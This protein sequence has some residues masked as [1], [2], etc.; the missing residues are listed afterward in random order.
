MLR[1]SRYRIIDRPDIGPNYK[2]SNCGSAKEGD[3]KYVDFG[4]YID[5]YGQVFICTLCLQD[6]AVNAHLYK[7]LE[8]DNL[9]LREQVEELKQARVSADDLR[10]TVLSTYEGVKKYFDNLPAAGDNS[11]SDS[12]SDV[13]ISEAPADS[14]V[15]KTDSGSKAP[16]PRVTEQITKS[17]SKDV[18]LLAD[19]LPPGK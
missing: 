15:N 1:M 16:Q 13:G 14:D 17:R 5:W 12:A 11:D 4:L 10:S 9:K 18:P 6:I 3:R 8:L 2:C 19:L 7:G